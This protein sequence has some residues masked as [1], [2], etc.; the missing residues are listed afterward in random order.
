M[1][2]L[3]SDGTIAW[4]PDLSWGLWLHFLTN[5]SSVNQPSDAQMKWIYSTIEKYTPTNTP[6]RIAVHTYRELPGGVATEIAR[7]YSVPQ[8]AIE[9]DIAV[10]RVAAWN[11]PTDHWAYAAKEDVDRP[12]LSPMC[13]CRRDNCKFCSNI[14]ARVAARAK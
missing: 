3:K 4:D 6:A 9:L 1:S 8:S 11:R 12:L 2:E 7:K 13:G 5:I 10:H 14:A